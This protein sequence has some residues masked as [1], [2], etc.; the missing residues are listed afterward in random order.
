MDVIFLTFDVSQDEISWL[1]D[2]ALR[3]MQ[4]MSVTFEVFQDEISWL[5][6]DA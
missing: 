3:N 6:D 4:L 2:D 1:K 5:K